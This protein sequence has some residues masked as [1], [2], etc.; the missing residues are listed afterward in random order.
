M[1]RGYRINKKE[2]APVDTHDRTQ[3]VDQEKKI[4]RIDTVAHARR[5]LSASEQHNKPEDHAA[6]R[7]AILAEHPQILEN[8]ERV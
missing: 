7:E 2:R 6:V 8:R 4:G 5:T 1:N 3:Y